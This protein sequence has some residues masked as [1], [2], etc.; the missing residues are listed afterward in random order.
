MPNA[1]LSPSNLI[2]ALLVGAGLVLGLGLVRGAAGPG[3]AWSVELEAAAPYD[4]AIAEEGLALCTRDEVLHVFDLATGEERWRRDDLRAFATPAIAGGRVLVPTLAHSLVA[5]DVQSGEELWVHESRSLSTQL[6]VAGE[7]VLVAHGYGFHALDL[8]T[9]ALEWEY[10][11]SE[12]SDERQ[13]PE[14]VSV[15]GGVAYV[16]Y[17]VR[18]NF[19]ISFGNRSIISG[20]VYAL[21]LA[22]GRRL[23]TSEVDDRV[24]REPAVSGDSVVVVTASGLVNGIYAL[25]RADGS[26]RWK[27][28]GAQGWPRIVGDTVCFEGIESRT[29]VSHG[30][31]LLE[32]R[33]S[34]R[35]LDLATGEERW[36]RPCDPDPFGPKC[37]QELAV[38][39]T[40]TGLEARRVGS[41]GR[42][43][44]LRVGEPVARFGVGAGYVVLATDTSES[45]ATTELRAYRLD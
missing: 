11:A 20:G 36:N 18:K 10:H 7:L 31:N 45:A 5:L 29:A 38:F 9:G 40:D 35:A 25:D 22:T 14:S 32:E 24:L 33:H 39:K 1:R 41:G 2:V 17:S 15:A 6:A 42:A 13:D 8:E 34:F 44:K 26:I 43:W 19:E 16:G 27:H 23:W 28:L 30:V 4:A 3:L 12:D 21:D 37:T